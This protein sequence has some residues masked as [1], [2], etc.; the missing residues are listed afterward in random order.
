MLETFVQFPQCKA[1]AH[2]RQ[3]PLTP[4]RKVGKSEHKERDLEAALPVRTA[5][6]SG[7]RSFDRG[8]GLWLN[9]RP[10]QRALPLGQFCS[11][12]ES[13]VQGASQ[14]K[15]ANISRTFR[16]TRFLR[17][18]AE[19]ALSSASFLRP[20]RAIFSGGRLISAQR[21]LSPTFLAPLQ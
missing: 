4:T 7:R 16:A 14:K 13:R 15:R 2:W 10:S 20:P 6:L 18:R 19:S 21:V 3:T 11:E 12:S 8:Y 9:R 17:L 5:L 1:K